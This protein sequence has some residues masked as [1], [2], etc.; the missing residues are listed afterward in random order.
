MSQ[1]RMNFSN[2]KALLADSD[3]EILQILGQTLRGFGLTSQ[4]S[5][6][7]GEEAKEYLKGGKFDLLIIEAVLRDMKCSDL[8]RWLRLE[9]TNPNRLIP[10]IVLTG[11]TQL[12][13]VEAARDS[14]ANIIVKKP[15]SPPVLFDRIAWT[16][17]AR[18]AFVETEAYVGPDRRFKSVGPPSGT[19]RRSTDLSAEVGAATDPNMSQEEIDALLRPTKVAVE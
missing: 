4:V 15:F 11:Y 10:I 7:A 17:H 13:M 8:I 14:G 3:R 16:A 18:R 1:E 6:E 9:T 2:V 5:A 19:G 12:G